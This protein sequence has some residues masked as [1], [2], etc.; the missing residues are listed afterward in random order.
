[1]L[2]GDGDDVEDGRGDDDGVEMPPPLTSSASEG[3]VD[4]ATS[5]DPATTTGLNVGTL[6]AFTCVFMVVT[7]VRV[8][9]LRE[10]MQ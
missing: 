6:L 4:V 5:E 8:A 3:E 10:L 9:T 2:E 1:M 7:I